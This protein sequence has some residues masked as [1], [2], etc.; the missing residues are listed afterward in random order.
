V[1]ARALNTSASELIRTA[2]QIRQK[3]ENSGAYG[4]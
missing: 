1:L 4:Q 2:E 3:T